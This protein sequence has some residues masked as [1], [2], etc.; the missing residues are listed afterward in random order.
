MPLSDSMLVLWLKRMLLFCFARSETAK[1]NAKNTL[2]SV[3]ARSKATKQ[4]K[5]YSAFFSYINEH[6][7][8][9]VIAIRNQ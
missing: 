1:N 9:F 8:S 2:L 4:S 7:P 3:I 6:T 5:L